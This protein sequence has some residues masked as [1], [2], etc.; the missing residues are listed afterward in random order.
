MSC[1]SVPRTTLGKKKP[2]GRI[3]KERKRLASPCTRTRGEVVG[4]AQ[5]A[6]DS[7]AMVGDV[8]RF[9]AAG[10]AIARTRIFVS[11]AECRVEGAVG[12]DL[13]GTVYL[14]RSH[15]AFILFFLL[16]LQPRHNCCIRLKEILNPWRYQKVN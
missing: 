14:R 10:G 16:F 5:N 2:A 4:A 3:K 1:P 15:G 9:C 13:S 6:F 11:V 8:A 12:I 7:A